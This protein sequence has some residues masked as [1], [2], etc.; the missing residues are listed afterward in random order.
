METT[1]NNRDFGTV[2]YEGKTYTLTCDAW[3]SNYGTSGNVAYYAYAKDS[4]GK[5]YRVMWLTTELYDLSC[6]LQQ[7]ELRINDN[8]RSVEELNEIQ[9]RIEEL[10]SQ[11]IKSCYCEDESNACDW[12]IAYRVEEM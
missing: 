9:K 5:E 4:D 7:L 6:E 2:K 8:F 10:E 11:G 12:E 3:C 1:N